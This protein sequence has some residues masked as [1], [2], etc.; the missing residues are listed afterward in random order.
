MGKR[1]GLAAEHRV[2]AAVSRV[3]KNHPSEEWIATLRQRLPCEAELDR[4]LTRKLRRRAGP[5]FASVRLETLVAG[6]DA[7][8]RSELGD[9]FTISAASWLSGGASKLQMAFTLQWHRPRLGP[10]TS[11]MVLRMEPSESIT[12]TS[13]LREYQ[14]IK[15]CAGV[16]P[17]PEVHWVDADGSFLPYPAIIYGFVEGTPK[18][19]ASSSGVSGVGTFFPPAMRG[20]LGAQFA[21][22]LGRIHAFDWRASQLSAFDKP[23]PGFDAVTWDLNHWERVWEEDV[24]ED[25]PLIRLAFAWLRANMPPVDHVSVVHGDYRTGNFLFTE[26]D[27]RITAWLDWEMAY[28]GDR[29]GDL[30]WAVKSLLGGMAEDGKTFLVGGLMP[31]QEFFAAYERASGLPV[32]PKVLDY[33]DIFGTLK[34][35]AICIASGYRAARNGKTH[36]DVLVAWLTGISYSLLEDLRVKLEAVL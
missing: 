25:V 8:L 27:Q 32:I 35:V 28:L 19:S 33:Y 3:D 16:V 31:R 14:I 12:E 4:I 22:Q 36:Q 2:S 30:A 34:I 15:A 11:R 20:A 26:H 5:P 9:D 23:R 18:P 29:H 21:E 7:L 1:C 24:N 6:V 10:T 17:L 13:R